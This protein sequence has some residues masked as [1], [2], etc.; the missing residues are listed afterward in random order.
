MTTFTVRPVAH[1]L[2]LQ[3]TVFLHTTTRPHPIAY[4]N[5]MS[6]TV[7]EP[8]RVVLSQGPYDSVFQEYS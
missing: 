3:S 8:K 5:T 1:H 7:E 4:L 2:A 6:G